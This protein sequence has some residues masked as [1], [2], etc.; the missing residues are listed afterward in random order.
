VSATAAGPLLRQLVR[1]RG[2]LLLAGNVDGECQ[3]TGIINLDDSFR[4]ASSEDRLAKADPEE[5]AAVLISLP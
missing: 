3:L 4:A 2:S 1:L 5:T